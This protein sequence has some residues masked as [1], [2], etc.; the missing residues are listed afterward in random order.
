MLQKWIY[1][2]PVVFSA[3]E[4]CMACSHGTACPAGITTI[5]ALNPDASESAFHLHLLS[6]SCTQLVQHQHTVFLELQLSHYEGTTS[7]HRYT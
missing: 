7:Q 3:G 5:I 1:H 6:T 2:L 4:V